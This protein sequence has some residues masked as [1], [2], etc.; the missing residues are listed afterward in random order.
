MEKSFENVVDRILLI[1]SGKLNGIDSKRVQD[2][3]LSKY[4]EK[5]PCNWIEHIR[6]CKKL[7][8]SQSGCNVLIHPLDELPKLQLPV[9]TVWDVYVSHVDYNINQNTSP[10]CNG[11]MCVRI[12]GEEYSVLYDKM[13][14]NMQ[15]KYS[16]GTIEGTFHKLR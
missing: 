15:L 12:L 6:E 8:L 4:N 16:N 13:M 11:F 2:R 5:L 10:I 14:E 1:V 9:D 3:Y 7:K